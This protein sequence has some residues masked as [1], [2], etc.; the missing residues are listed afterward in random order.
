M[1]WAVCDKKLYVRNH[2]YPIT[3]NRVPSS[4]P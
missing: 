3:G 4:F 1:Q 2:Q